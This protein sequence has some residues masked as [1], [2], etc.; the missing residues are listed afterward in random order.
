MSGTKVE[1]LKLCERIGRQLADAGIT[2]APKL[3]GTSASPRTAETPPR[4]P[5]RGNHRENTRTRRQSAEPE[6]RTSDDI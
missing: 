4:S 6:K 3:R 5:G 1:K 2:E